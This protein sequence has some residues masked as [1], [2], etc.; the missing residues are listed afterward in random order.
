V[1]IRKLGRSSGHVFR[2]LGLSNEE[3]ESLRI[4]SELMTRLTR[5]IEDR[6]LTQAEAA[7][8]LG[9]R[10]RRVSDLMR[11]KIDRFSIDALVV[12]LAKAGLKVTVTARSRKRVA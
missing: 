9:V 8:I 3:S 4:R 6:G 5:L 10:Q 1:A 12:L 2:A 7:E 11:E